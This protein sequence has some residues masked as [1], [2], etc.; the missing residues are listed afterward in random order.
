LPVFKAS[1]MIVFSD[2]CFIRKPWDLNG[3]V[4]DD[5]VLLEYDAVS[6]GNRV[7][8]LRRNVLPW[9]VGTRLPSD[10]LY[11]RSGPKIFITIIIIGVCLFVCN[12]VVG[13]A[14]A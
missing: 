6:L 4:F 5:P 11:L 10:T 14:V 13:R 8:T 2:Q 9:N 3:S 7:P 12:A 1:V